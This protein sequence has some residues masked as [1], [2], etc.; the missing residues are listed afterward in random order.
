M[1]V[2]LAKVDL[3]CAPRKLIFSIEILAHIYST[4]RSLGAS[5]G[6]IVTKRIYRYNSV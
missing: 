1:G 2:D 5:W 3:V 4:L 6:K